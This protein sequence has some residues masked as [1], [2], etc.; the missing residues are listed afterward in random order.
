MPQTPLEQAIILAVAGLEF[1]EVVSYGDV[2]RLAGHPNA[3]RAVG[4][5]LKTTNAELPWW[6]V[7]RSDGQLPPVNPDRQIRL[8]RD[9]GVVVERDRVVESPQ[10]RFCK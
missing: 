5:L 2:A 9:E 8:L 10:G 3:H 7:V 6:R 1:G 4:R